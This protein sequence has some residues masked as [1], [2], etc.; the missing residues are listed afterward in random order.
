MAKRYW[1][2]VVAV[3]AIGAGVGLR[4]VADVLGGAPVSGVLAPV[5]GALSAPGVSSVPGTLNNG[6]AEP[7]P[8]AAATAMGLVVDQTGQMLGQAL[9]QVSEW[10]DGLLKTADPAPVPQETPRP[11]EMTPALPTAPTSPVQ[12]LPPGPPSPGVVSGEMPAL[13][14][15][16][17][18]VAVSGFAAQD[19]YRLSE[20]TLDYGEAG[21][22]E[23]AVSGGAP[24]LGASLAL[25]DTIELSGWAG[26]PLIG[27]RFSH[28]LATLCGQV[29]GAAPVQDPTP[30]VAR[31]I[32]RNLSDAGW[33][34]R[35]PVSLLPRCDA[36]VLGVVAVR[37]GRF[38]YPL[39]G[40]YPLFLPSE[41]VRTP[42]TDVA[43]V[44]RPSDLPFLERQTVTVIG[45]GTTARRCGAS[46]CAPVGTLAKG[47]YRVAVVERRQGW[48]LLVSPTVSGWVAES[49]L[50]GLDRKPGTP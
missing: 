32:H 5:P 17:A 4:L 27:I 3:A 29:V 37:D 44:I 48:A 30:G 35:L 1:L 21:Y 34:L 39:R 18:D 46:D 10:A 42:A 31:T 36:P 19:Q 28:V 24:V 45:K 14:V 16:P 7:P 20:W 47:E 49:V 41:T 23:R 12:A 50:R 8:E 38:A 25:S 13:A 33:H 26:D 40:D 2:G 15:A 11:V 43:K 6:E 22:V 9:D